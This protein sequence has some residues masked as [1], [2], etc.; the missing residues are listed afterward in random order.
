MVWLL[1]VLLQSPTDVRTWTSQAGDTVEAA[2]EAVEG[3]EVVLRRKTGKLTRIK[4]NDLS[5][6]DAQFARQAARSA[7]KLT[8]GVL[9][10]KRIKPIT[11]SDQIQAEYVPDVAIAVP[12]VK[13]QDPKYS[14]KPEYWKEPSVYHQHQF[15]EHFIW[16]QKQFLV[17]C[18]DARNNKQ[19]KLWA[20]D[21][22]TG[23]STLCAEIGNDKAIMRVTPNGRYM[24]G[25]VQFP[26]RG[27]AS[28]ISCFQ[29]EDDKL[30]KRFDWQPFPNKDFA[31]PDDAF[32]LL[33]N[34]TAIIMLEKNQLDVYQ[35]DAKG[36]RHQYTIATH[37]S[38]GF[39]LSP[40]GM[41]LALV[42]GDRL[43]VIRMADKKTVYVQ[44]GV[45]SDA[46]GIAFRPDGTE[47]AI[48]NGNSVSVIEFKTGKERA[49]VPFHKPRNGLSIDWIDHQWLLIDGMLLANLRKEVMA[50]EY[51]LP[52][53]GSSKPVKHGDYFYFSAE[54]NN[55][56]DRQLV[57]V[58]LPHRKAKQVLRE[59]R[60]E[61]LYAVGQ[62][63]EVCIEVDAAKDASEIKSAVQQVLSEAGLVVVPSAKIKYSISVKVGKEETFE[64]RGFGNQSAEKYVWSPA[65]YTTKIT[66]GNTVLWFMEIN[67]AP[68]PRLTGLSKGKTLQ[69][70][71][72]DL[73]G[74]MLSSFKNTARR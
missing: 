6:A 47:I 33:N 35:F 58:E 44:N 51:N 38:G 12:E 26:L 60:P 54:I 18:R 46:R 73:M 24:F 32:K 55:Q 34:D 29:I 40:N 63:S 28:V 31:H 71:L 43:T 10:R 27:D 5:E 50:W 70:T 64:Y 25:W 49:V 15:S 1:L 16:E 17:C 14:I 9:D 52:R 37:T 4:L 65:L 19:P 61:N 67:R 3:D 45:P 66:E 39:A 7:G 69:Q 48:T 21:L 30:V 20:F 2:F 23:K 22:N 59:L 8:P 74:P 56:G 11:I 62:G 57:A 72:D 41:Y 53:G 13:W 68:P 36:P 42:R